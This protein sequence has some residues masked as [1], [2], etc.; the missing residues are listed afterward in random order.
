M[1]F[2][3][4]TSAFEDLM[5]KKD[6]S[7]SALANLRLEDIIKRHT[8]IPMRP[9]MDNNI[10]TNAYVLLP[11]LTV[12]HT[13]FKSI[14]DSIKIL[15]DM[16]SSF[17]ITNEFQTGLQKAGFLTKVIDAKIDLKEGKVLGDLQRVEYEIHFGSELFSSD[18][19]TASEIAAI[20]LHEV[21]HIFTYYEWL[22]K[23]AATNVYLENAWKTFSNTSDKQ[24]RLR[25]VDSTSMNLGVR[26]IDRERVSETHSK[27]YFYTVYLTTALQDIRSNLGTPNVDYRAAEQ[28]ADQYAA[29][30]GAGRDLAAALS[31][32]H[33]GFFHTSYLSTR[34]YVIVSAIRAAFI[35][36]ISIGF[37]PAG[38]IMLMFF[39]MGLALPDMDVDVYDDPG[40]RTEKLL[41]ETASA[42]KNP[43]LSNTQ[44]NELL[45][46]HELL[47]EMR[48][49]IKDRE[50]LFMLIWRNLTSHRRDQ[51]AQ[52]K[53]QQELERLVNN[54][55]FVKSQNFKAMF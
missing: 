40:Q 50:G 21:G 31:K 34:M 33:R 2:K 29:R 44:R 11:T 26:E 46:D 8:G 28:V 32:L 22:L 38:F 20:T 41:L 7:L 4:L 35:V 15:T 47:K 39:L 42:L 23:T 54:E 5:V 53:F 49:K 36:L 43:N 12:N 9:Y 45:R 14:Q 51:H 30:H 25:I 24:L 27:E 3:E 13:L 48:S 10:G 17:D 18:K 16:D 1:F 55:L 19:F 52:L 6:W 37:P